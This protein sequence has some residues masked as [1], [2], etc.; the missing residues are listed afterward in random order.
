MFALQVKKMVRSKSF[1]VVVSF[2]LLLYAAAAILEIGSVYGAA[3]AEL[4]P[5]WLSYLEGNA[6]IMVLNLH[7]LFFMP[8]SAGMLCAAAYWDDMASGMVPAIFSRQSKR[9]YWGQGILLSF[10][11]AFLLTLFA[12]A[13]CQAL[14]CLVF[15]LN[16][17]RLQPHYP[18]FYA[19][20]ALTR[21]M[22]FWKELAVS[23][24]YLYLLIYD[25]LP[26]AFAGLVSVAV[27][28]LGMLLH[29][30]VL[31]VFLPGL[32]IVA[33]NFFLEFAGKSSYCPYHVLQSGMRFHGI[34]LR[35]VLTVF[36]VVFALDVALLTAGFMKN[37]D[38]LPE[39]QSGGA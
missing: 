33:L 1:A 36:L 19:E 3:T 11:S 17:M 6:P 20:E 29:K 35:N 4:S 27:Y 38:V 34:E 13:L 21:S 22:L 15:P 12:M 24:P 16:S 28:A 26:A 32:L 14:L 7:L 18:T 8:L 23:H 39:G 37:R 10:L 9:R 25:L 5:A 31:V 30:R 2:T